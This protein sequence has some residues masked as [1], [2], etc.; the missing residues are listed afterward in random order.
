MLLSVL[1]LSGGDAL[2]ACLLCPDR[3]HPPPAI[4]KIQTHSALTQHATLFRFCPPKPGKLDNSP[5][6]A[7]LWPPKLPV[8]SCWGRPTLPPPRTQTCR[9]VPTSAVWNISV[10]VGRPH[11]F[12]SRPHYSY[13]Y[14]DVF[15]V[16]CFVVWVLPTC[17][18]SKKPSSL[19]TRERLYICNLQGVVLLVV[20]FDAQTSYCAGIRVVAEILAVLVSITRICNASALPSF[21]PAFSEVIVTGLSYE[22][23]MTTITWTGCVS[24]R[25]KENSKRT[26]AHTPIL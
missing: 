23:A 11:Y 15:L 7:V 13:L 1:L 4:S 17:V 26:P 9:S 19:L 12:T 2:S 25:T 5:H 24:A 14:E 18:I 8:S 16:L 10:K 22:L 3:C 20:C 6:S 21:E